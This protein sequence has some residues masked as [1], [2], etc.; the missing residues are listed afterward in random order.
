MPEK[1]PDSIHLSGLKKSEIPLLRAQFGKNNFKAENQFGFLY[2]VWGIVKEPMFLML[3]LASS[4]YFILGEFNEGLLMLVA[5]GFVVAISIYQETKSSHALQSLRQF[6]QAKVSVIRDSTE[7][8]ILTEELLPGDVMILEEGDKVP[9][10]AL[11]LLANDLTLN[12]SVITG[13]S[14]PVDKKKEEGSNQLFHGSLVNSGS[15]YAVV[16]AI[17]NQTVLGKI[18]K[19]VNT[20]AN[21]KTL[22]QIQIGH[23]VKWLAAFGL[24]AFALIWVVNFMHSKDVFQSLLLGLTLA[25]SA[26]PEE[27]PVAFSA[28]MALGAAKMAKLGIITRQP[29]TIENLGAVSV[30]CLDKTG[31]ITQNKMQV[32]GIYSFETGHIARPDENPDSEITRVLMLA[33]LACEKEPFDAMEKAITEAF[34]THDVSGSYEKMH[35]IHEYALEGRPPMMTHVYQSENGIIVAGKGAP[36]RIMRICGLNGEVL[37]KMKKIALEMTSSGYRVLGICSA[38]NPLTPFPE[39]QDDFSWKYE[40]LLSLYDPPKENIKPVF[41]KWYKAGISIN[42]IT[43]DY[44]ET[45]LNIAS[46]AGIRHNK[47][48][49]TGEQV[50]SIP[51][52]ELRKTVAR[53]NIYARMFPEAKLKIVNIL[54]SNGQIVAMTGDGV[55]DALALKAADI[56]ISM[57][58]SGTEVAKESSD[59]ILTDDNLEKITNAITQGRK[60]YS[61]FKKAVRYIISI[62]IPIILTASLPLIL[63]W[64]YPAVF[65]PIHVIFLELIMG[66]TCSIF[67]EREPEEPNIMSNSPR[68]RT[69]NIF[70][71]KELRI[72]ILQGIFISTGVLSLYF[73]FM[74]E[75]Y[76][77]EYVRTIV[78]GTLILSNIFLTFCNRSFTE[79][80]NKTLQ[81]KNTL[82]LW[83]FFISS[84]FLIAINIVPVL[85]DLFQLVHL[86]LFHYFICLIVSLLSVGWVEFFKLRSN[87]RHAAKLL[88]YG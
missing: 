38:M 13:E 34:Q 40:G 62:H 46:I 44:P 79:L 86:S 12:E 75:E 10:D 19:A 1:I 41:E 20:S 2:A 48:F 61:N 22:L 59:L 35:F 82:A 3:V 56:G 29:Q 37:E 88:R 39:K 36:E 42:L 64:K 74:H 7:V 66:P 69:Q 51:D 55:N 73:Y 30:I 71:G 26:V 14:V 43:G 6:T 16:T 81:Y 87:S 28:F 78:Y 18:G 63:G 31:T 70:S 47:E 53:I 84:G 17:G 32:K 15:C 45:A 83:V 52:E 57:G 80:I 8:T 27:I 77:L 5:M 65:T 9:A 4:I 24:I 76:S 25:M 72:S 85:Q 68:P 54:K 21:A 23:F 50:M 58:K 49:I 33:R 67:Y 11:I 60:I